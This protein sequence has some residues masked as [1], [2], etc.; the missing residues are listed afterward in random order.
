MPIF[1]YLCNDCHTQSEILVTG[2]NDE[3]VC[4][5]CGSKN[6]KKMMSK[7]SSFSGPSTSRFPGLGDTSCCGS[8]PSEAG[9]AGPGSCCGKSF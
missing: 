6:I 3:P 5:S 4:A 2:A 8:K 1:D 7:P 9:C